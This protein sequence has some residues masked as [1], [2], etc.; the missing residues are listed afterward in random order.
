MIQRSPLILLLILLYGFGYAYSIECPEKLPSFCSCEIQVEGVHIKCHQNP[1]L[2]ET[3]S[4][5]QPEDMIEKLEIS[6]CNPKVKE[7]RPLP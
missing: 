4:S 2:N 6:N 7:L 3:F 5:I 1:D